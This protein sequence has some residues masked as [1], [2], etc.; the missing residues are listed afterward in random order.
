M[1][2]TEVFWLSNQCAFQFLVFPITP[3]NIEE[4][5]N[6]HLNLPGVFPF[7]FLVNKGRNQA[8][9]T[10]LSLLSIEE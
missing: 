6:Y 10:S 7:I 9:F 5:I 1:T 2:K 8:S 3:F 4:S